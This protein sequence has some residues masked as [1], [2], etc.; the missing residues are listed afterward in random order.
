MLNSPEKKFIVIFNLST[1]VLL[2]WFV[3]QFFSK[4]RF[5]VPAALGDI[6]LLIL[7]F[8]AGDK[9]F[10]RWRRKHFARRRHGEYFV[11]A[12]AAVLVLMLAVEL[13]G[14]VKH[15]YHIPSD[16]PFVVGGVLVIF[17]ITEYLKSEFGRK[18]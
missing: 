18:R 11:V 5:P 6:Y 12:W 1:I 4:G 8:Y 13:L 2:G 9:E 14:G 17:F 3:V 16:V 10:H 7:S 15:D